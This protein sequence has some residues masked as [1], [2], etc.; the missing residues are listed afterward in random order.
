MLT[1]LGSRYIGWQD[2]YRQDNSE[3]LVILYN[4]DK[5]AVHERICSGAKRWSVKLEHYLTTLGRKPGALNASLALKQ[6]P[7]IGRASCRERV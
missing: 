6:M 5:V 7:E 1:L 3:K 4:N 2:R